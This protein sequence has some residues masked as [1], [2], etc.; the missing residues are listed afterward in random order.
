MDYWKKFASLGQLKL[1]FAYHEGELLAGSVILTSGNHAWNKDGGSTR[2]KANFMAPRLIH[3]EAMKILKK[4]GITQYDLG[5]I[6][7][8]N[9]FKG[10][11][12]P[13]IYIFK[14]GF[15]KE[16]TTLMPTMEL[17]LSMRYKL[18]PKAEGQWLRVYNL[19]A[20]NLW[21]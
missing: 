6:P 20:H 12:I 3:W 2:T 15:S 16:H 21:W 9:S 18:W 13:G 4:S 19:F 10:S 14:S 17:T 8:P 1:F 7:D 11:S 5:G